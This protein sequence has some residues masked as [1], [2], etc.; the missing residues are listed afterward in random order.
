ML[1]VVLSMVPVLLSLCLTPFAEAADYK[2]SPS[3]EKL[4]ASVWQSV[5]NDPNF[6]PHEDYSLY[7]FGVYSATPPHNHNDLRV[8]SASNQLPIFLKKGWVLIFIEAKGSWTVKKDRL[9]V[10]MTGQP[11]VIAGDVFCDASGYPSRWVNPKEEWLCG[12]S[13]I[14]EEST[15]P[16]VK[17]AHVGQLILSDLRDSGKVNGQGPEALIKRSFAYNGDWKV[18][19]VNYSPNEFKLFPFMNDRLESNGKHYYDNKGAIDCKV[20]VANPEKLAAAIDT[21]FAKSANSA[22]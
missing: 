15:S 3:L 18:S 2:W 14:Y 5:K 12:S 16:Q 17:N 19:S 13:R 11:M 20:I 9:I 10:S 4:D 7:E 1:K 8:P 21:Y 22:K 6:K